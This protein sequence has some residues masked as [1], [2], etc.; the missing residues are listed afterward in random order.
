MA[1]DNGYAFVDV[2]EGGNKTICIECWFEAQ[3]DHGMSF[4]TR[5]TP[6]REALRV[7]YELHH[8]RMGHTTTNKGVAATG[9]WV[10]STTVASLAGGS[11][12]N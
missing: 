1:Q 10:L 12:A 4:D 3:P 5:P 9:L 2:Q 11:V 6:D 8:S 7:H